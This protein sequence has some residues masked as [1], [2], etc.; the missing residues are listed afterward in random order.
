MHTSHTPGTFNSIARD[1]GTL[2]KRIGRAPRQ[3]GCGRD[4]YV[5]HE[6]HVEL[7]SC[8][9]PFNWLERS[10]LTPEFTATTA[11][12]VVAPPHPCALRLFDCGQSLWRHSGMCAGGCEGG[13]KPGMVSMRRALLDCCSEFS[14]DVWWCRKCRVA[15]DTN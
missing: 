7:S 9:E 3:E 14:L 8:H 15:R 13:L 6:V 4:R 5:V 11:A 1:I 2:A 10:D 12:L